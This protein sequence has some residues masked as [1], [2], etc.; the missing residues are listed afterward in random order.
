LATP[1]GQLA[2]NDLAFHHYVDEDGDSVALPCTDRLINTNVATL[3]RDFGINGV[4]AHKGEPLVRLS[5][6]EAINGDGLAAAGAT[7]RKPGTTR[8]SIGR[9]SGGAAEVAAWSAP[10]RKAGA[11]GVTASAP[12]AAQQEAPAAEAASADAELEAL[13]AGLDTPAEAAAAAPAEEASA[14]SELDALLASLDAPAQPPADAPPGEESM[15][16][17]LDALLKSLG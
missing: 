16:P 3:L 9:S 12:A 8:V 15:D 10:T 6:L 5:G 2:I 13:L 7:G 4:M 1:G 11:G 17:D 14:D